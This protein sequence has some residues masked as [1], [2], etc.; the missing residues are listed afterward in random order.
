MCTWNYIIERSEKDIVFKCID[1]INSFKQSIDR[2]DVKKSC[3][4]LRESTV[5]NKDEEWI[6]FKQKVGWH[7]TNHCAECGFWEYTLG[8]GLER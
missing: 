3:Q 5:R 2:N 4:K 1:K 7:E 8:K 6:C